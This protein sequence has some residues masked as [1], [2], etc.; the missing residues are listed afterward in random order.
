MRGNVRADRRGLRRRQDVASRSARG[1]ASVS[2]AFLAWFDAGSAA[3]SDKLDQAAATFDDLL[4]P[5]DDLQQR[6]GDTL[7]QSRAELDA[8]LT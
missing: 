8:L 2:R 3:L 6:L 7:D 1:C 4:S 5:I